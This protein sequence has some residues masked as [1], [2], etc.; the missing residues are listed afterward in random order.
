MLIVIR[1]VALINSQRNSLGFQFFSLKRKYSFQANMSGD[2]ED[3]VHFASRATVFCFGFHIKSLWAIDK[4]SCLPCHHFR[5]LLISPVAFVTGFCLS[6]FLFP[7][8]Y[9]ILKFLYIVLTLFLGNY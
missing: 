6:Q 3:V 7:F 5:V 2:D 1:L 8:T 9:A 4:Y